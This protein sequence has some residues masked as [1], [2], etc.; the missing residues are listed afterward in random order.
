MA[1]RGTDIL[2]GGNPEFLAKADLRTE[3]LETT[4]PTYDARLKELHGNYKVELALEQQKVRDAGGLHVIGTERHEARRI[5]NQLRGRSGRRAIRD[6]RCF[7]SRCRTNS[8]VLFGS[9]RIAFM[10]DK[11]GFAEDDVLEHPLINHS[12][13]TAQKRVE[14]QTS[15]RKQLLDFDNVMNKQRTAVYDRRRK[16]IDGADVK[17]EIMNFTETRSTS[18]WSR[19]FGTTSIRMP[20]KRRS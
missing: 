15:I 19:C 11:L 17:E 16:A 1:G 2:L 3:G 20:R 12:L 4:D 9:D 18:W 10:M 8:C 7:S 5:D 13:E 6:R 14:G